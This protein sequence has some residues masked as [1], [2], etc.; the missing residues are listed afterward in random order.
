MPTYTSNIMSS[1]VLTGQRTLG[2][3]SYS[4]DTLR[5]KYGITTVFGEVVAIDPVGVKVTLANGTVLSGRPHRH[6]ARHQLR[7][8]AGPGHDP[9]DAARLAGRPADHAAGP[10]AQG[11]ARPAACAVLTIPQGRPTAARPA[12]TSAPA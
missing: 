12:R 1:L 9:T 4:Y 2:S 10:A 7:H 11:H 3:L 6:G 8:R 5:S